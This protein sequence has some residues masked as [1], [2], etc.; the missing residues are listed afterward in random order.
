MGL[1][2]PWR[3]NSALQALR[4][5]VRRTAPSTRVTSSAIALRRARVGADRSQKRDR[6]GDQLRRLAR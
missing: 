1:V 4:R 5:A 2:V 6:L 3:W